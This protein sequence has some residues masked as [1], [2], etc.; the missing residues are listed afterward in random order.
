MGDTF[1]LA[2]QSGKK[3]LTILSRIVEPR[4]VAASW[5]N[6]DWIEIVRMSEKKELDFWDLDEDW[7]EIVRMRG[8]KS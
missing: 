1:H 4:I 2:P 5:N 8:K 6:E 3:P 7:R